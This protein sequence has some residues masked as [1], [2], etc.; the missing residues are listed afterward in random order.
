MFYFWQLSNWNTWFSN[1]KKFVCGPGGVSRECKQVLGS[2]LLTV[3]CVES[4]RSD[5]WRN[6]TVAPYCHSGI[7]RS[8]TIYGDYYLVRVFI[9]I[10]FWLLS[11]INHLAH[12]R[13]MHALCDISERKHFSVNLLYGVSCAQG[14]SQRCPSNSWEPDYCN[15]TTTLGRV[16]NGDFGYSYG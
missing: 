5:G 4:S 14:T 3:C 7:H 9:D 11:L 12:R 16:R 6:Q 15:K 13:S 10:Y 8:C 1:W 2:L